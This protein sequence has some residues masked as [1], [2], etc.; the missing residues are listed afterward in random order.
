MG[1]AQFLS[2]T[3]VGSLDQAMP[4]CETVP[5]GRVHLK[6]IC[7]IPAFYSLDA[8]S[9]LLVIMVEVSLKLSAGHQV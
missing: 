7:H 1:L 9:S 4:G 8:N 5:A 6:M 3:T 2:P